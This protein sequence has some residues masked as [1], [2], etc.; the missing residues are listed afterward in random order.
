MLDTKNVKLPAA[1]AEIE[2]TTRDTGI[3]GVSDV[4][5]G[6]FLRT[7]VAAKPAGSFLEL[8]TGTGLGTAWML[9]GMDENARLTTVESNENVSTIARRYLSRDPRVTFEIMDGSVFI[10]SCRQQGRSFDL[11]FADAFPGKFSLLDE[12][13]SLLKRG[14]FYIVDDLLFRPSW[15]AD[16]AARVDA[17]ITTLEQR[18]DVHITKLNWSTGV[19]VAAKIS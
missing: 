3:T 16:Y 13:F 11:I 15:T 2:L 8:G 7:L 18:T 5:T 9:D 1:L 12:T 19:I 10:Q 14:G 17:L 6:M 4:L